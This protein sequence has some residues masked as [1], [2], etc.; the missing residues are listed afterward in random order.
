MV[1]IARLPLAFL[2]FVLVATL[3]RIGADS[4]FSVSSAST[5]S[6]DS[7]TENVN[8]VKQWT[9][10]AT[11]SH[12]DGDNDDNDDDD[13]DDS[14]DDGD[15]IDSIKLQLPGRVFI[16]YSSNLP[17]GVLGYVNVSGDSQSVVDTVKVSS[18]DDDEELE[19]KY[20]GRSNSSTGYLLTEIFLATSNIVDD[21]EIESTAEVVI[22][23]GVL[24]ASNTNKEV[25]IK[26]KHSSV[27]YV[28]SSPMS[29]Q[30]LKLEL[31]DSATLQLSTDSITLRED[32][33][34]Q[35]HDRSSIN[36]LTSSLTVDDL[37]L[38]AENSGTICISATEVKARNYDGQDRSRISLPNASSKYTST[39][40][41]SCDEVSIPSREPGC[42]SSSACS[43]TTS[44]STTSTS[45]PSSSSTSTTTSVPSSSTTA[46]SSDAI[47]T[48]E[49]TS[50]A[51]ASTKFYVVGMALTTGL[52]M[53]ISL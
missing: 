53:A 51:V 19:V 31:S 6:V 10:T 32:G 49:Q 43:S 20:D 39:G 2:L 46:S 36:V 5:E 21:V 11:N 52:L 34:F 44:T 18:N 4:D 23:D 35:A 41:A 25:Q 15:K 13:S 38:D 17:A 26:A 42:V 22:E 7:S 33:Q 50:D 47:R 8:F 40:T 16:S 24:F 27:V 48:S 14:S 45:T 37:D 3:T 1:S 28:S 29:L 9:L 12:N 30:D